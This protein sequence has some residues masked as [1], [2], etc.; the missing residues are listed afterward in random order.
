MGISRDKVISNLAWKLFERFAAQ[1]VSLIISIVLARLLDPD[2]YGTIALVT[3]FTT[4]MQVFIDSG[5]GTALI[6]KKDATDIDFSSVFYFNLGACA[7]LYFLMFLSAPFIAAFYEKP[8]LVPIIRL[9]SLTLIISGI[10]NVQQAYVSKH[11]K[12]H[13]FFR[14]TIFATVGSA[15]VG[16][17]MAYHG[18]GIWSL[19]GQH[20]FN[21]VIS[22]LILWCAVKWRPKLLFSFQRLWELLSFGWKILASNL[23][24]TIYENIRQLIIGKLYTTSD[25]AFYNKGHQFPQLISSNINASIDSVLFPVMSEGQD[26]RER[27]R[28]ITR[29]AI[30]VSSYIM[31]PIM[32]GFAA[33]S[34]SFIYILLT[35]K[36][37]PAAFFLRIFCITMVLYPI[38]TANLNAIKAMGRSDLFLKLEVFKKLVGA[39][40]LLIAMWMGVKAMAYSLLITALISSF[41]NAY[42]NKKLLNYSYPEQLRDI[43]PA[44]ALAALMGGVVYTVELL[45]LHAL[46]TLVLQV[47]VGV[48]VYVGGSILFKMESYHYVL[49]IAKNF[50]R[51]KKKA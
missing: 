24:N 28:A 7:L 11:M 48:A 37:M 16:V 36:W 25:L 22:T 5:L 45:R 26:D 29:R 50:L 27:V 33:C 38:H 30:K 41:I 9:L 23:L 3:V 10:K 44:L 21:Q 47:L 34:N 31:M 46:L 40:T 1:G 14:A 49:S 43:L 4:I 32:L 18:F 42:P 15:V 12:F 35:E 17:A 19:V 13:L 51:K 6:Q 20:L 39:T 8:E 2:V